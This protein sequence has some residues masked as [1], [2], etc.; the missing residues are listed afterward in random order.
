M[1]LNQMQVGVINS[2][3]NKNS[4]QHDDFLEDGSKVIVVYGWDMWASQLEEEFAFF[5]DHSMTIMF[6]YEI[7]NTGGVFSPMAFR[8]REMSDFN[9]FCKFYS[10]RG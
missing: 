3:C 10:R 7:R 5:V 1:N 6:G 2:F 9:I 4:I 8:I